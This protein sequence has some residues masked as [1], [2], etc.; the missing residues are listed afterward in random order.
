MVTWAIPEKHG[1]WHTVCA[2]GALCEPVTWGWS[3]A[4]RFKERSGPAL[5]GCR[6]VGRC[7]WLSS[8]PRLPCPG[9]RVPHRGSSQPLEAVCVSTPP[10]SRCM[11][12]S[13]F[14]CK[15][16]CVRVNTRKNE[17]EHAHVWMSV[18]LCVSVSS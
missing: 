17:R 10:G 9:H 11:S 18:C 15:L 1:A 7:W 12:V 6:A 2:R 16:V 3:S 14:E 4:V 5:D 8:A 13:M